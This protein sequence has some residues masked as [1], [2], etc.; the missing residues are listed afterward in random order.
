MVAEADKGRA[1]CI[2]K[3]EKVN[4]MTETRLNNQN[5]YHGLKKGNIDNVRS[6]V[7][8]KLKQLKETRLICE[9]LYKDLE[10]HTLKTPS[11]R[12]LLKIQINQL[13]TRLVINT[14]NPAV[15]KIGKRLS[16]E[17]WQITTSGKSFLQDSESF[18][19]NIKHEKLSDD[20]QFVSFDIKDMYPSLPK[21]DV[22]SE[23]KN[24]IND[25]KFVNSIDKCALIELVTLPLEFTS[26]TIYQKY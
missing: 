3:K 9:K 13:K 19:E 10:P 18:V 5:R 26:F 4:K 15:C 2:I 12:P 24:K 14:Q 1:T 7:N 22:L 20:E 17:L 8:K 6:K 21:Y 11:A 16:K 23:I 25:N